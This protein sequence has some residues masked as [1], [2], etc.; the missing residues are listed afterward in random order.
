[1]TQRIK[2]AN[3][4]EPW[5]YRVSSDRDRTYS[6]VYKFGENTAVSTTEETIWTLG[7][8]KTWPAAAVA[9]EVSSSDIDDTSAGTGAQTVTIEGL[10]ANYAEISETVDMNGQTVDAGST[11]TATFLRVNRMFVATAGTT[12]TNEGTIYTS[13]GTQTA[14]VPTDLTTVQASIAPNEG[15][16]EHA[17][18]TIPAG[19]T[20]YLHGVHV[21][22]HDN[23]NNASIRIRTSEN[24]GPWL[25][26][27]KFLVFQDT[28]DFHF[29]YPL[30]FNEKTDIEILGTAGASTVDVTATFSLALRTN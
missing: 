22:C 5:P 15:Q 13:T 4:Y 20:G 10:D 27:D 1:M 23:T 9:L 16:S 14:G 24:G 17:A 18:Y 11:T 12:N 21:S 30:I 6:E 3:D 29:E 19:K 7:G 26:Q 2:L 28:I 25:V 8:A